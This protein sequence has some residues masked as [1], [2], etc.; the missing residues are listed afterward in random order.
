LLIARLSTGGG[1]AGDKSV[2]GEWWWKR[3]QRRERL[4]RKEGR[5]ARDRRA[6]TTLA[7]EERER[8]CGVAAPPMNRLTERT[9][10]ENDFDGGRLD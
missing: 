2:R 7:D 4:Q 5:G 3:K 6:D 8:A 10:N 9:S 1:G